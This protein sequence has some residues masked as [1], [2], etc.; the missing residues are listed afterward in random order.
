[1]IPVLHQTRIQWL[2][3]LALLVLAG[4]SDDMSDL[5]EF[6]EE[7]KQRPGGQIEEIPEF[8]PYESFDYD[9]AELRDPFRPS[10][11]F[12]MT[13]EEQ[14]ASE[15]ESDL[16]PDTS[17]PKEPLEQF[18]LDSLEMVGTLGQNGQE[19]GLVKSPEG[20]IHRVQEGNYLGQNY[21]RITQLEAERIE[22]LEIV[23]DGQG[24]WMEREAAL[25]L[26]EE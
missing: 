15:S 25:S 10:E 6:V 8:E 5:R 14:A 9:S 17:R 12:G 13:A 19:W 26:G 24:D 2:P 7:T 4:C 18:P 20:V 11:G 1:M 23:P 16:A 22:V 21:G 3:L